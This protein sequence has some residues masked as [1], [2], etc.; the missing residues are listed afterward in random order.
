LALDPKNIEALVGTA[1]VDA[2]IGAVYVTDDRAVPFATAEVA[3]IKAL[4]S[5]PRHALAHAYLG[6]VYMFTNRAAQGIAECERAL[7]LNPNLAATH[8]LIGFAKLLSGR[9]EETESHVN[10]ALRLSPR[11]D[12]AYVWMRR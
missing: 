7:A 3:L 9:A 8:G 5:A 4:S 1:I 2:N 11:D 12:W 10:E 6:V